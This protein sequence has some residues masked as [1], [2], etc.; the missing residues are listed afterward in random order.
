MPA[1]LANA[2]AGIGLD[3]VAV[4]GDR[5]RSAEFPASGVV[6]EAPERALRAGRQ[7]LA[8]ARVGE[9]RK[10]RGYRPVEV[11]R[12][13]GLDGDDQRERKPRRQRFRQAVGRHRRDAHLAAAVAVVG[14]QRVRRHDDLH[15]LQGG[16]LL[17]DFR[18]EGDRRVRGG[19]DR[20]ERAVLDQRQEDFAAAAGQVVIPARR[21]LPGLA[22]ERIVV[23]LRPG[24]ADRGAPVHMDKE[25]AG[26]CR[27]E[28]EEARGI[29]GGAQRFLGAIHG[30]GHADQRAVD[31]G[32][33]LPAGLGVGGE[34]PA[35]HRRVHQRR[36]AEGV[37]ENRA[38]P[39]GLAI[40][41][42][43]NDPAERVAEVVAVQGDLDPGAGGQVF[44]I[45]QD[46]PAPVGGHLHA[47][48][49]ATS[50]K[51]GK[52]LRGGQHGV[53]GQRRRELEHRVARHRDAVG[54]VGWRGVGD[55]GERSRA[56][57]AQAEIARRGRGVDQHGE[58]VSLD[59]RLHPGGRPRG[60]RPH[61]RRF[62][63]DEIPGGLRPGQAHLPVGFGS[64]RQ[65]GRL[66][67]LRQPPDGG[68]H[69]ARQNPPDRVL[70]GHLS[71]RRALTSGLPGRFKR[72]RSNYYISDAECQLTF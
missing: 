61:H 34:H 12:P 25:A 45:E 22:D 37:E 50:A 71:W 70:A 52:Q 40:P 65:R 29:G 15:A 20:L 5:H 58:L 62:F 72:A 3:E 35:N 53:G 63:E 36:G 47:S 31:E 10:A 30:D 32:S 54:S 67:G 7:L 48:Q 57:G 39:A 6:V 55:D 2:H 4:G 38:A 42:R 24:A 14:K 44:Q 27:L 21:G 66:H 68:S 43:V 13:I 28:L 26:R 17:D 1:W 60:A 18:R 33:R 19:A 59:V 41:I 9:V 8:G 51:L 49:Q 16:V 46:G 64:H 56:G 23:A 69:H 11:H